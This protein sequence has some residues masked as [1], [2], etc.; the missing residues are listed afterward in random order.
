MGAN[1]LLVITKNK[2]LSIWYVL[3]VILKYACSSIQ[4]NIYAFIT[5][6]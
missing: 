6:K 2:K 5:S 3:R 4:V 1:S